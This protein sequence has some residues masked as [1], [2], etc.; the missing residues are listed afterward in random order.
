MIKKISDFRVL[1]TGGN[2]KEVIGCDFSG[3]MT[4][5]EGYQEVWSEN[6]DTLRKCSDLYLYSLGFNSKDIDF[7]RRR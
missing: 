2:G 7:I 6:I 4:R 1:Y 5:E 3:D